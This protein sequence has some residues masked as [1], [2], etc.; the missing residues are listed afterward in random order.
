MDNSQD[1]NSNADSVNHMG[2]EG[3]TV[4]YGTYK[5]VLNETKNLRAKHSDAIARLAEYE[6]KEKESAEKLLIEEKKFDEVLRAKEAEIEETRNLLNQ[7]TKQMTD[8]QKMTGFLQSLGGAK[9]ESDYFQLVEL[10]KIKLDDDG[11]LDQASLAEYANEFKTRHQRLLITPKSD[12]PAN[13]PGGSGKVGLTVKEWKNLKS[14]KEMRER[15]GEVDWT[16][17]ES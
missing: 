14:S 11:A 5:K 1:N 7:S 3:D 13:H 9:L 10:D 8:Y 17:A 6:S 12:V 16:T 4:K 2:N 15:A